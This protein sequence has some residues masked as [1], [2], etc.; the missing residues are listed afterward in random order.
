[1][2]VLESIQSITFGTELEYTGITRRAAAIAIFNVLG[3]NVRHVGGAY[4]T[5]TV[6]APDGRE[7]NV[8][9]D[10]SLGDRGN[11][12]EVVT[13]ILRYADMATLQNVVRAL[14]KAGAQTPACTS[15][16]VHI[17]VV[18][19]APRQIANLARIYYKQEALILR[20]VGTLQERLERYTR[21]VDREFIARLE[22][23]KPTTRE[24]LNVAWFGYANPSP[25]HYD[26]HRY[27][28][29]NLNNVWR[30]GTVEFRV[31]NGTSHAGVVRTNI[32]FCLT[33]AAMALSAKCASSKAPREYSAA[34]ARYDMRVFLLRLGWIGAEFKNPRMHLLGNL[35]GSAA[36][37][38][39]R[40]DAVPGQVG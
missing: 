25:T 26:S 19:W 28:G 11:S 12:A 39:G 38:N 17:G 1:M 5:W 33:L 13:P 31:F 14:R 7:W 16:H 29:L 4:D 3:G 37:K 27:R 36:W 9:S 15:Q 30:T 6:F 8:V 20:A 32:L 35:P 21:P 40:R 2:S 34:S 22:A 24:E 23:M 18:D 10:A